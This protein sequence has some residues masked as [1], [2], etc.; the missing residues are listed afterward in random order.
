[1]KLSETAADAAADAVCAQL[2]GGLLRLYAGTVPA[3]ADATLT[4][5]TFL[6][7]LSFA[8]PAFAAAVAG[9]AVANGL[10]ND[11][12]AYAS[13]LA[14]FCIAYSDG[15]VPVFLGT[16]GVTGSGSDCELRGTTMVTEHTTVSVS[17]C[18]YRQPLAA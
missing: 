3:T 8:S 1:M 17:A 14:T 13:G 6:A 4:T 15:A 10:T 7:A 16:V 5:Q 12:D 2:N 9:V 18:T 11:D